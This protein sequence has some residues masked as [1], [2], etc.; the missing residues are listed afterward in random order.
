MFLLLQLLN[1]GV[2]EVEWKS[3]QCGGGRG[4][5]ISFLGNAAAQAANYPNGEHEC[6]TRDGQHKRSGQKDGI[7][8]HPYHQSLP[9]QLRNRLPANK[10]S[11]AVPPR[12]TPKGI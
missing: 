12:K 9:Y 10:A 7:G 4:I 2:I 3:F 11:N 1:D 6:A 8:Q 5:E